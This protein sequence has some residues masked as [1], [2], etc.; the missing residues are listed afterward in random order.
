MI[1]KIW[2]EKLIKKDDY[3]RLSKNCLTSTKSEFI[4][5]S[6]LIESTCFYLDTKIDGSFLVPVRSQPRDGPYFNI[7]IPILLADILHGR[8]ES[9]GRAVLLVA[10]VR[11]R[12]DSAFEE[13]HETSDGIQRH[14]GHRRAKQWRALQ[15]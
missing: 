1:W 15:G 2:F 11:L 3:W 5:E 10:P 14:A 6:I 12:A 7:D 13:Y 9:T 8:R 4:S